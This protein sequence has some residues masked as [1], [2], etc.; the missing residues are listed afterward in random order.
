[1]TTDTFS[2][3]YKAHTLAINAQT[4]HIRVYFKRG[5]QQKCG[6][7]NSIFTSRNQ[8]FWALTHLIQ[9]NLHSSSFQI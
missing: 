8:L 2:L 5:V 6:V 9:Y 4:T 3:V 7:Q 1:M